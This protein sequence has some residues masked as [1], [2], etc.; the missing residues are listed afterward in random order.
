M[1]HRTRT[2][3]NVPVKVNKNISTDE[4]DNEDI[5]LKSQG[6]TYEI[7]RTYVHKHKD[8]CIVCPKSTCHVHGA[9]RPQVL[10]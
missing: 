3:N 10:L 1:N 6:R 2:K 9:H 5:R 8:R 7:R 4:H